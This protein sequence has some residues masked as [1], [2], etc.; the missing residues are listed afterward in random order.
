MDN[1]IMTA[2]TYA[3][4]RRHCREQGYCDPFV[5]YVGDAW[6]APGHVKFA[7]CG[8]AAWWSEAGL[9]FDDDD[10]AFRW[11]TDQSANFVREGM[12]DTPFWRLFRRIA[13]ITPGLAGAGEAEMLRRFA[14]TNLSK[15]GIVGRSAPP[16]NDQVLRELDVGQF[17][18]EM[19]VLRPDLLV[20]VSG[21]LV[22][23][24]GYALFDNPDWPEPDV[25]VPATASTWIR[26]TPWGGWLLW[27]MH[28]A[29]KPRA[30][31]DSVVG[32]IEATLD[33][34]EAAGRSR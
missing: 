21:S 2:A 10:A 25:P 33:L 22:P 27:T 13:S 3:A 6:F 23:S 12:Y 32:D 5:P 18:H 26:R 14:W 20:C 8:G 1:P 30:W 7:Y 17:R 11:S 19:D 28:P 34:I 16:D 15:T 31:H 24:T 29:Y 4:Y 9:C